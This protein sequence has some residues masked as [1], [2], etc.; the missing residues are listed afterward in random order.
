MS[1]ELP[2]FSDDSKEDIEAALHRLLELHNLASICIV[3][4]KVSPDGRTQK[5]V[6]HI[7]NWYA[8]FGAIKEWCTIQDERA[9]IFERS[10]DDDA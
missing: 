9:R 8:N 5:T 3:A 7:G 1:D 10:G 2:V 6:S 4:T